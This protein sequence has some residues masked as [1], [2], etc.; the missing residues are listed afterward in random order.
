[1]PTKLCK[2]FILAVL[3]Y[4]TYTEICIKVFVREQVHIFAY[5]KAPNGTSCC[6]VNIDAYREFK[7]QLLT[8][9][10]KHSQIHRLI[11]TPDILFSTFLVC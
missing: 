3:D 7:M 8:C 6:V 2:R 1:M 9:H 4:N 10:L 5:D 11:T